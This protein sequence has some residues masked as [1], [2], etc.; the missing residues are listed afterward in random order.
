MPLPLLALGAKSAFGIAASAEAA[1]S[2][3]SKLAMFA[4]E[5][6]ESTKTIARMASGRP[7][8]TP[9]APGAQAQTPTPTAV[10]RDGSTEPV[11]EHPD[12]VWKHRSTP[13]WF[14]GKVI[15]VRFDVGNSTEYIWVRGLA[16]VPKRRGALLVGRLANAPEV[17]EGHIGDVVSFPIANVIDVQTGAKRVKAT[18]K[19]RSRRTR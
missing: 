8:Q 16:V 2:A 19:R 14:V 5:M 13:E 17:M 11:V 4:R 15:K 6:D 9:L 18:K 10:V 7:A 3:T 1:R 12:L